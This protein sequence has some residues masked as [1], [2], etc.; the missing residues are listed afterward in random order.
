MKIQ[1]FTVKRY[2]AEDGKVFDWYDL[3]QHVVVQ[4][5]ET[6][7]EEK[8]VQE[9][10]YAKTLFLSEPDTILNYTEVDAPAEA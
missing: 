8:T 2:D 1:D 7:G 3:S 9:H 5:D 4:I 10:L 6:T